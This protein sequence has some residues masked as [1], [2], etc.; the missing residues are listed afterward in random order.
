MTQEFSFRI[1]Y[2]PPNMYWFSIRNVL[3]KCQS[4][5]DYWA[6][7]NPRR[8]MKTATFQIYDSCLRKTKIPFKIGSCSRYTLN[9]NYN[10][11]THTTNT[12]TTTTTTTTA[13]NTTT[14]TKTTTTTTI[15][16]TT[17]LKLYFCSPWRSKGLW[18]YRGNSCLKF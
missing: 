7:Y 10:T 3:T 18:K 2:F 9:S 17:N 1:N 15:T 14:T 16:T 6:N 4:F 11:N 13:T 12:T 8:S 5:I